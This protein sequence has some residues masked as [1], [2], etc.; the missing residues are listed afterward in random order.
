MELKLDEIKDIIKKSPM[1]N[2]IAT[3]KLDQF[4]NHLKIFLDS[5][6]DSQTEENQKGYMKD[7]LDKSFYSGQYLISN[8]ENRIDTVIRTG[9]TAKDAIGVIIETKST[10]NASEM[11]SVANLHCKAFYETIYYY[12][13]Q[14]I[15]QKNTE[16][17]Y[18]VITNMYEWF[19]IDAL[20][21]NRLFFQNAKVVNTFKRFMRGEFSSKNT[22]IFYNELCPSLVDKIDR[23]IHSVHIDLRE[24]KNKDGGIKEKIQNLYKLFS[25]RYLLKRYDIQDSNLLNKDFYSELLY[26]MGLAEKDQDGKR[27]IGRVSLKQRRDGA[28]MENTIDYIDAHDRLDNMDPQLCQGET[29]DDRLFNVALNLNITWI[30]RLLFL[31][32]LEGQ[33]LQYHGGDKSYSFLNSEK[34][35]SYD[36]LDELF[37]QVLAKPVEQRKE[38][39]NRK[40]P[41]VPYLNS[42]LFEATPMEQGSI[43]IA[44]LNQSAELPLYDKSILYK[45][46]QYSEGHLSPLDYLLAFL[47]AYDFGADTKEDDDPN[48]KPIIS[49][50][51]LGLIFEKINGYKDGS[52][53][54]PSYITMEMS[55]NTVRQAIIN[56]FNAFKGWQCQSFA[57]LR[58]SYGAKSAQVIAEMNGVVDSLHI[59][60][61]AV[62]SGHYLVSALNELVCA[63]ADLGILV[64]EKGELLTNDYEI[65]IH[66]DELVI[67]DVLS[68]NIFHYD[69]SRSFSAS[70]RV[71][72]TIFK[73]KRQLI[74]N[75]L[76]GV[77]INP[78][79]VNICR[80]R[81]W[82]EL[83]K[84]TYYDRTSGQLQTLPN[85]DINI[86]CGNSLVR[87]FDLHDEDH[88]LQDALLS[89]G[90]TFAD[91]RDTVARYKA[92]GSKDEKKEANKMIEQLKNYFRRCN[93]LPKTLL[94]NK[95]KYEKQLCSKTLPDMFAEKPT[96][97]A[98]KEIDKLNKLISEEN[99]KI[100]DFRNNRIF[101]NSMEWRVEFPEVLDADGQ[102]VG[103]DCVIGNPPYMNIQGITQTQPECKDYYEQTYQEMAQGNYDLC[104]LF[105]KLAIEIS[106]PT[107]A[108]SFIMPHKFLN[109]D[110]AALF[111]SYLAEHRYISTITHFGA[112]MVFD[113]AITYTC[114]CRFSPQPAS[115][116]RFHLFPYGCDFHN[117]G[118]EEYR[119]VS[120]DDIASNSQLYGQN[121]WILLNSDIE[122]HIF[123]KIYMQKASIATKFKSIA[124]GIA[125]SDDKL[126]VTELLS[127]TADT[128]TVRVPKTGQTYEVEKMF[129]KH[130]LMGKQVHRF[131]TLTSSNYVFF[132]YL[133]DNGKATPVPL[134]MLQTEYPLTYRYVMDNENDFKAREHGK[135]SEKE[136][137][138]TYIYP[139]N[140]T[141]FDKE[142]L[143]SMEICATCPNVTLD[144]DKF[145][146]STTVY[147]WSKAEDVKE[148]YE[149][150]VAILNSNL[151]WWY[152]KVTGDTLSGDARR[153]KTNY[154]NP[155]PMPEGISDEMQAE[156]ATKVKQVMADKSANEA[157][158][159]S[160][161]EGELDVAV[162]NLYELDEEEKDFICD[163]R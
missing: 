135:L 58:N 102:F 78:N 158:D 137:W 50:S 18:I 42:S 44:S 133:I 124:Q 38:S 32:L 115:G 95:E 110:N 93:H 12:L 120:Y 105:F 20:E 82:I 104:N 146:H 156:L 16:L 79:S 65:G 163:Y 74:E 106:A 45:Y 127:E 149:S 55:R 99:L 81:L 87:R 85:I 134:Q 39:V 108:C 157:A 26:I 100:E 46:P 52:I 13:E 112:N 7:F 17:K 148:N 119:T 138:Y 96:A 41:N 139:K 103:F 5:L 71:Q 43:F 77:D 31:K 61:P 118:F 40:F 63:K 132:P 21:Y 144:T 123:N 14:R 94:A 70:Q 86:K 91:Y 113:D 151:L 130:F 36:D 131:A 53:F 162:C 128:Y 59:C 24:W 114:I 122:Q 145:Y 1:R 57:D 142:K 29:K 121:E 49:A 75:C 152:L 35:T 28:M 147:N 27:V 101:Q 116:I 37:F 54:T 33:L 9:A 2:G 84:F 15:V 117:L 51:V 73:Q 47:D 154:L 25:P 48:R 3:D 159:T 141:T 143:V 98:Q 10:S 129:F 34:L 150:L 80:L 107:A 126:Y 111:R 153:F 125:T 83:L 19:I 140:L 6:D 160:L 62:G 64:D 30:N 67:T 161:L 23:Q 109:T 155:F 92:A 76:F 69:P 68:Q 89:C 11:M 4:R 22:P 8:D 136:F 56:K 90:C 72:E 97:K 60:D 88:T 66:N